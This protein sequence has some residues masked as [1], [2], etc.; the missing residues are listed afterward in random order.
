MKRCAARVVVGV[1]AVG[2]A[3]S[4]ASGQ[5]ARAVDKEKKARL[6]KD[7]VLAWVEVM[8]DANAIDC[9]LAVQDAPGPT[10][11]S[12]AFGIVT[13][14]MCDACNSIRHKHEP[15][16]SEFS[17]Y[18]SANLPAAVSVAAHDTLVALFPQ[19]VDR[20]DDELDYWL[21]NLP[22]GQPRAR[23]IEL[24][25]RVAADILAARAADGSELPMSYTPTDAPGLHQVDP[26]NPNQPFHA[27]QWG[28]VDTF[29][30]GD[31]ADWLIPPPPALDSQDYTDSY[32]QVVQY[33]GD[34]VTTPTLRN[35]EQTIIGIYWAYDGT[36]GIGKPPRMYNQI[37]RVIAEQKRNTVEQ[38]ARLFAL[39]NLAMAD[40]GIQC[41]FGKYTHEFWRPIVGIRNG[42]D[43]TNDDTVGDP[44]WNPLGAPYTNG[45]SG[46][47]NFTP[48]FPAYASGHATFGAATFRVV[49]NFYGTSDIPFDFVSDEFNG[50]NT[51]QDG[52]VRPRI[53]RH[54]DTLD[55]AAWENAISR[56][57]LGIH[58]IFDAE[59]GVASGEAIADYVTEHALL[60]RKGSRR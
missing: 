31:A 3:W 38:N 59:M 52:N 56:I 28:L 16:L 26:N 13:A 53:V 29:V 37:V 11:T 24:G 14:A 39:V 7:V 33:G 57:Y 15:Y 48:P 27:P 23:G 25:E 41:W 43:D 32:N 8:L 60:P 20:F 22:A 9:G 30:I 12:R 21:R 4:T 34:G 49:A 44:D 5:S 58:W 35:E 1:M 54:F 42:D 47:S 51:D 55:E 45:P 18:N 40:A 2:L 6:P 50:V 19:Q 10:Y 36:P 17:G 46:A